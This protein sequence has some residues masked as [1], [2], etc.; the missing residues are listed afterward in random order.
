MFAFRGTMGSHRSKRG[1]KRA[2]FART[3]ARFGGWLPTLRAMRPAV[4]SL[5]LQGAGGE[6]AAQTRGVLT[7]C[8]DKTER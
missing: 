5:A 6:R 7:E 4:Y 3:F 2:R 8:R 1:L